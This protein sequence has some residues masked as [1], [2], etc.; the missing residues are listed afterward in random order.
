MLR[1]SASYSKKV[2]VDGRDYSSQQY[3]AAVELELSDA[4]TPQQLSG[5]IHKTFALVRDAVE[6]ELSQDPARGSRRDE[7][8]RDGNGERPGKASNKQVRFLIDLAVRNGHTVDELNTMVAQRFGVTGLYELDRRQAS[9]VIDG[10]R[11]GKAA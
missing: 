1:L 8:A 11:A 3:H 4:E 6:K 10:L 2:P 7:P 9:S 5:R